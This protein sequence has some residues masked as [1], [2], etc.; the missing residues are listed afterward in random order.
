MEEKKC[1]EC[2]KS[3]RGRADKKFCSAICRN[4]YHN[5]KNGH[6]TRVVRKINGVLRKNR[7]ILVQFAPQSTHRVSGRQLISMGFDFN[8]YT[9]KVTSDD[10]KAYFY[11]YDLGYVREGKD[12]YKLV[13]RN[14]AD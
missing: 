9:N 8:Y 7:S 2:S 12:E 5:R 3:I 4:T 14:E 10:G 11:C 1:P 6:A 13:Q